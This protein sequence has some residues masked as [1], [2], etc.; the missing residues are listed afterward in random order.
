M[1]ATAE[2]IE[3]RA[4]R[5]QASG[6]VDLHFDLL[7]D[8]YE[9]RSR[10]GV[11]AAD[12]LDELRAGTVGVLGAAI[13]IEDR[14]LP[15]MALRVGLDQIARLYCEVDQTTEFS[16]VKTHEEIVAARERNQIAL[17]ITMEGI[18]PL[19]TDLD[20]LRVFYELG[21]RSIGLT[22]A[23]RNAA[24]N[25]GIFAPSGSPRDGLT[26][27]GR[28]LVRECES[29]GIIVDLAHINPDGFEEILTITTKPP[30][31]SHTNSRKF[32]DVERN[33]SDDQIKMIGE[34][35]GVI[36]VNSILVSRKAEESTLDRYVDHIA[37]II[38]LIGI[39]GVGVGF[40]FF[41]FIYTQ[42][43]E[44]KKKELAAKLTTPHF[45]PDLR[46][47]SHAPNLTRKLIERGFRDDEIE[48]ILRENWMRIFRETL[49]ALT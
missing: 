33:I 39:D 45:I 41:E 3:D 6:I 36:G 48:K 24:G 11:L 46:N 18:E 2:A 27:F 16:I 1:P 40:D 28:D 38:D 32:Y 22:H 9:K 43:P 10:S 7:M 35:H 42:W 21:V 34:H 13:Y 49:H 23:R 8:L 14:Y 19:G 30:I 15:E 47:H 26:A 25:G 5:L 37:H 4:A 44:E 17:L 20:L 31:V 29:L 12:F